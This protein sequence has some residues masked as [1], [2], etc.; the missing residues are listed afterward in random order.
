M[1]EAD[2][3]PLA[4]LYQKVWLQRSVYRR[5][6]DPTEPRNFE[7]AG[8]M[9]VIQDEKGLARLL[10]DP[11]E[12]VWVA[13]EEGRLLG[14]LWCGLTDSKYA[15]ASR[16]LPHAGCEDL[17]ERIRRGLRDGVVYFSKEI[18]VSPDDRGLSL[19]EALLEASMRF[20][21]ARG[22]RQSY[23]EVYHVHA[24]RDGEGERPVGLFQQRVIP[25]A[26]PHRLPGG[27]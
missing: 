10:S 3:E 19:P 14:A 27:G 17:P 24:L 6:L 23:G 2:I 26:D 21:H 1:T 20:F 9:F 7:R 18:L 25:H 13:R 11:T 22:F 15:D 8:G 12:Y 4:A 16:I 5:A